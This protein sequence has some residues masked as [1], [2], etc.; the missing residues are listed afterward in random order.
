MEWRFCSKTL[1]IKKS[2]L[3]NRSL[4]SG[5]QVDVNKKRKTEIEDETFLKNKDLQAKSKI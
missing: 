2:R 1:D 5:Y 4:G 3:C